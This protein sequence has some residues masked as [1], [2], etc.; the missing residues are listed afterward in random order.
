MSVGKFQSAAD[1]C[2]HFAV[3]SHCLGQI[4]H[5]SLLH[6]QI[7]P[8]LSCE[9]FFLVTDMVQQL[10]LLGHGLCHIL[11]CSVLHNITSKN[12]C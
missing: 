10:A 3:V 9:K 1:L 11:D 12:E 8:K 6:I 2:Q 7:P 4:L 5:H